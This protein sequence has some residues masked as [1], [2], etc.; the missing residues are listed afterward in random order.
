M[1]RAVL[2]VAFVAVALL[3]CG[4]DEVKFDLENP[5]PWLKK[6]DSSLPAKALRPGELTGNCL[7]LDIRGECS[8][9]VRAS[10]SMIRKARVRLDQG[11]KVR[12]TYTPN[13][14]ANAVTVTATSREREATVPVRKSGGTL[15]FRCLSPVE[16]CVISMN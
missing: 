16:P 9:E 14:K 13:E 15:T 5:P 4:G 2:A 11:L 7:G 3:G 10:K 12:I 1:K 6:L 8:A